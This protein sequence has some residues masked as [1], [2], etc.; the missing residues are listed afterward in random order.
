VPVV[1]EP[2]T[3]YPIH[4][5]NAAA[6]TISLRMPVGGNRISGCVARSKGVPASA[7]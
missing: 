5:F 4:L 7:S 3:D 1:L 6:P 2:I